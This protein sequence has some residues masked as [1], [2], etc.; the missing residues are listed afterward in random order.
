M[1]SHPAWKALIFVLLSMGWAAYALAGVYFIHADHLGTPRVVSDQAGNV[2]WKADYDAFGK[3]TL[4]TNVYALN[5]R[6]PGQYFDAET[7]LHY[8]YFRDYDPTVGRYLQSDPIGLDGG[9]NTYVY[10]LNSPV[11]FT[12]PFGLRVLNPHNYPIS[13]AVLKAL[14][15]FNRLI[16]CNKDIVITGGDRPSNSPIGAG[17]NSTHAKGLAADV[18]VPGQA[19]L[20]SANQASE[21]GL[22]GGVGW[23]EEAYRAPGEGPHVHVDLRKNGPARWGHPARGPAMNGFFPEIS[24]QMNPSQCDC[25]E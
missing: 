15:E 2:V 11:N 24:T 17:S 20:Q 10:A 3:A 12:D 13:A 7:N 23:Y 4:T 1:F 25:E 16:G 18:Y 14:E 21:S 6:F 8:N 9:I 19:H 22:F 5:L